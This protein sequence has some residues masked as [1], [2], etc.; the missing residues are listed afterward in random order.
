MLLFTSEAQIG[1]ELAARGRDS[2]MCLGKTRLLS[3]NANILASEILA[4]ASTVNNIQDVLIYRFLHICYVG[5][6]LTA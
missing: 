6:C 4:A 1:H 3:S 2:W 5:F